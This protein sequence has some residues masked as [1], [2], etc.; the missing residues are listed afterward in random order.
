MVIMLEKI[1]LLKYHK[2]RH[3]KKKIAIVSAAII[4]L[5][6][7]SAFLSF[8]VFYASKK[9]NENMGFFQSLSHLILSSDREL[10]AGNGNINILILGIGGAGHDGPYLTDTMLV[11]SINKKDNKVAIISIPRDLLV[12]TYKFGKQ[13]IN[14]VNA[15]AEAESAG[16]GAKFTRDVV[17]E[18]LH[19]PI[20]FYARIDFSAFQ[21]LVDA[22]GGVDIN[23]AHAFSD[24][25]YP[26]L[27]D[28]TQT[29]TVT[30]DAGEQHMDGHTALVYA[31]SRH[32]NNNEGSDFARSRR[33]EQIILALKDKIMTA[34]TLLSP[35]KL[36]EI[37][38]ILKEHIDTNI[39]VWEAVQLANTYKNMNLAPGNIAMN[40]LA[41][42]PDAPLYATYYGNQ[43]VLF[44]KKADY[45][46][47]RAI[48]ADPWSVEAKKYIGSYKDAA[49]ISV[50]VLNGTDV[51]GLASLQAQALMDLGYKVTSTGNAPAKNFEKNVI[52]NLTPRDKNDALQNLK[53][54]LQANVAQSVPAWLK[55]SMGAES[56]PDFVVIIGAGSQT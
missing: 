27:S 50:A 35:A 2:K 38:K 7:G 6:F 44:P 41:A 36:N 11:A 55:D 46:D 51:A 26:R 10:A 13:K 49:G 28:E 18:L 43:Y 25:L 22:V 14:A 21:E 52:Y 31:R 9:L 53:S 47:L 3:H 54:V 24:P 40:V 12:N 48:A 39:N 4:F 16:G 33:Q 34:G 15:Y 32:G 1:D 42:G 56:E 37:Y 30:F 20:N 19:I 45:S 17:A 23:V 29:T 8:K 5:I